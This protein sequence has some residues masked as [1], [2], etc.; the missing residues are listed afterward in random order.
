MDTVPE[1]ITYAK[2]I[3]VEEYT[4][5]KDEYTQKA[6][7]ELNA[8]MK[9]FIKPESKPRSLNTSNKKLSIS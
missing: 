6:L 5:Q 4:Q 1:P 9:N 3:S 2:K 8:Q 7:K